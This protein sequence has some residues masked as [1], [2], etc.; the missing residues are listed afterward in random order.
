[1]PPTYRPERTLAIRAGIS[2]HFVVVIPHMVSAFSTR[3][4]RGSRA[5]STLDF[6]VYFV[7]L[8]AV[9]GRIAW[10]D[11]WTIVRWSVLGVF[12]VTARRDPREPPSRSSLALGIA[13]FGVLCFAVTYLPDLWFTIASRLNHGGH[14]LWNANRWMAAL[15]GN[16]GRFLWSHRAEPVSQLMRWIY[17]NGFDMVVWIP[18]VRSLIGFASQGMARYALAAHI[19][20][21][22]LIMPF[23]SA[24]RVDEVWSVLG[25]PDRCARGW[26]DEVR[27]DL[28][29]NCF[30]SMHTSVAFAIL[31]LSLR[32]EAKIYRAMM[33]LYATS[34]IVS[35]VYMEI[36]WLVDVAGGIALGA[37]SVLI[38]D[39][40]VNWAFERKAPGEPVAGGT[41]ESV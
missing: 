38:A 19:V 37:A 7:A 12:A 31:L 25:D 3:R 10:L 9:I 5:P 32:D 35:T 15:P 29:A 4:T 11:D 33:V 14:Y 36:H 21:F 40:I 24:F 23:Y 39:R 17:L 22:P 28:G 27:N 16:D 26:S 41:T 18:V 2:H 20:Q 13:F 1:M 6:G 34:I 8:A 30:P